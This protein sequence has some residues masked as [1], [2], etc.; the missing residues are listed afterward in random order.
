MSIVEYRI[1]IRGVVQGIGFRPSVYRIAMKYGL[2][3]EIANTSKGVEIVI[4]TEE[5]IQRKFIREIRALDLPGMRIDDISVTSSEAVHN[6]YVGFRIR[7]SVASTGMTEIPVDSA[8]CEEC[9]KDIH[10]VNSQRFLYP[11]VACTNC[12]PRIT[13]IKK[14]PY[15]RKDTTMAYLKRCPECE[16]NYLSPVKS[17]R[18]NFETDSCWKCSPWIG[19]VNVRTRQYMKLRSRYQSRVE[20][21]LVRDGYSCIGV[22]DCNG[23]GMRQLLSHIHNELGRGRVVALKGVGGYQLVAD[24]RDENAVNEI[25]IRK[26]R[27]KKPLAVMFPNIESIRECCFCSD[28]CEKTLESRM[29]PIVL[30]RAKEGSTLARNLTFDIDKVGVMLPSSAIH[31]ILV[32]KPLV[33]T[34]ANV[35]GEPL[36]FEDDIE[37]LSSVADGVFLHDR[38]IHMALDD[39]LVAKCLYGDIILRYARGYVPNSFPVGKVTTDIVAFGGD[40][41]SSFTIATGG[42]MVLSQYLGDLKYDKVQKRYLETLDKF[43]TLYCPRDEVVYVD[44]HPRYYSRLLGVRFAEDNGCKVVEVQHHYAHALSV[45]AEHSLDGTYVCA[46]LDGTGFG[47]DG[48]I[49]GCEVMM[50]SRSEYVRVAHLEYMTL[51]GGD[52]AVREPYRLIIAVKDKLE[53]CYKSR[54]GMSIFES[55]YGR[56]LLSR[57]RLQKNGKTLERLL[58]RGLS[59]IETSS[60]G[61]LFDLVAS[62]VLGIDEYEYE[63]EAAMYVEQHA[64]QYFHDIVDTEFGGAVS[65]SDEYKAI[66]RRETM[67]VLSSYGEERCSD[68][69]ISGTEILTDTLHGLLMT[70]DANYSCFIFH[71]SLAQSVVSSVRT[72]YVHSNADGC[73]ISGGVYQNALMKSLTVMLLNMNGINK[74][75]SND[76]TTPGD[77]SISL[78]Q[79]YHVFEDESE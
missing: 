4:Q 55:D 59:C 45:M 35:S 79:A 75:Y 46:V 52:K 39:S 31:E 54:Y 11:L 72:H 18:F 14:L 69:L 78:G 61:R 17:R 20:A 56:E 70:R 53:E 77:G 8:M 57:E 66:L 32:D 42:R 50:V 9:R 21:C 28:D 36:I 60:A 6:K 34:S 41:K 40:M 68:G 22:F 12:G 58:T 13:V 7:K 47:D 5:L 43:R 2:H 44:K 73:V 51:I 63:G 1:L 49:W 76:L 38:E 3:G 37:R 64:Q 26:R 24:A 30:V 25:R 16:E 48:R 15:D 29:A 74:V 33:M 62:L 19:Y 27:R 23:D 67:N 65:S 10:E 71:V